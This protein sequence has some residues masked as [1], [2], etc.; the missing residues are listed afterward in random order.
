MLLWHTGI[1]IDTR[2][3]LDSPELLGMSTMVMGQNL[4]G[5][6]GQHS[7]VLQILLA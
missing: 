4:A 5:T 2:Q 3:S 1:D 7:L 6:I